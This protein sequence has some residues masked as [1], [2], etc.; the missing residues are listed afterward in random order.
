MDDKDLAKQLSVYADS[1]VVATLIA[2]VSYI[3]CLMVRRC[4]SAENE[5][6]RRPEQAQ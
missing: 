4:H 2:A 1:Y 6:Y 5:P 3:Y